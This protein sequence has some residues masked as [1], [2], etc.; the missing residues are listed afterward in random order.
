[1][2]KP[3]AVVVEDPLALTAQRLLAE[4]RVLRLQHEGGDASDEDITRRALGLAAALKTVRK[5]LDEEAKT[6][7]RELRQLSHR[8]T[9]L[10]SYRRA[11]GLLANGR[12]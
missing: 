12:R 3:P 1:M 7:E 4:A 6:T 5:A 8:T 10:D 9:A 11:Q 2:D